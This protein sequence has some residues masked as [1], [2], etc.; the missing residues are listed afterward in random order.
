MRR[1]TKKLNG[2]AKDRFLRQLLA[3]EPG[4]PGEAAERIVMRGSDAITS[5]RVRRT[6]WPGVKPMV[7]VPG[8]AASSAAST[9]EPPA[10]APQP[11]PAA[12]APQPQPPADDQSAFDPYA[13]GLVPTL[14]REGRDGLVARLMAVGETGKL[15]LMARTQQIVLAEPY[16]SGS[17]E[18]AALAGAIAD[19]VAKRIAD[20]K[21]AA[22]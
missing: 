14:Q 11:Q 13:I 15:R 10:L 1:T 18:V 17:V 3:T 12:A 20:R 7:P 19:A 5:L 8:V 2:V 4:L 21:A 16:K 9:R 22:R 6:R